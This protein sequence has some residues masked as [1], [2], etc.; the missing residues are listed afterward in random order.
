MTMSSTKSTRSHLTPDQH[1]HLQSLLLGL[2]DEHASQV[3]ERRATVDELT[4]QAD[5]DSLLE[6]ELAESAAAQSTTAIDE[7]RQA[8][9]RLTEGTYGV[10]GRC[11][12]PIPYER[13]EAIPQ[14]RVCVACPASSNGLFS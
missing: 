1:A 2:L 5:S 10:C 7:V 8:L 3:S 4:G 11:A 6:R 13:L 12:S 9:T 14:T